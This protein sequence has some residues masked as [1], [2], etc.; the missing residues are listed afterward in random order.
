MLEYVIIAA[1]AFG[2]SMLTFFS[3]FGLGTLLTPV[4]I[5][6]FPPE[7]AVATT[8]IVHF[9]NNLFKLTL[10]G[11]SAH[12][13]VVIKFGFPAILGAFGGAWLLTI[14]SHSDNTVHF[15]LFGEH[16]T[17]MLNL[18][19][20]VLIFFFALFELIPFFKKLQFGENALIPGGILSGFFG[21]LSGHQ[22]ALR[23]AFL[24]KFPLSK[25]QFIASGVVIACLVDTIRI[26]TYALSFD[27]SQMNNWTV[28]AVATIAAFGGAYL[29]KRALKKITIS[30]IQ[31][32]VGLLMIVIAALMILG[33]I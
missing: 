16:E 29:G 1:V 19:L 32:A 6:F 5:F 21:G 18:V 3:G 15:T 17:Y 14:L 23:S 11:R 20:G 28:V 7:I 2:A 8:A 25:E 22:G 33:Y 13:P 9:L 24:I 12:W 27:A 30:S 4:L 31:Y 26:G 10:I